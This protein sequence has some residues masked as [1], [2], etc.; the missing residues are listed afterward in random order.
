MGETGYQPP[1]LFKVK[2]ESLIAKRPGRMEFQ[3]GILFKK[4]N[5]W[6]VRTTGSQGSAILSSM[7]QANCFIVL[8]IHLDSVDAGSDVHV[9]LMEG[10]V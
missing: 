10:F 7:T 1:P 3:R 4:N 5:E 8:D 2:A 9:Q 6:W